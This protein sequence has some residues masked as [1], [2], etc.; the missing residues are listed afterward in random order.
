MGGVLDH[1]I[2]MVTDG[3]E[4]IDSHGVD[5]TVWTDTEDFSAMGYIVDQLDSLINEWFPGEGNVGEWQWWS[6]SS[7]DVP[8]KHHLHNIVS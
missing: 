6:V 3:F 5:I 4:T 8:I 2:T 1:S 7:E